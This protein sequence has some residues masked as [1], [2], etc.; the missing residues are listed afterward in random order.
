MTESH[1]DKVEI[2][3]VEDDE[4]HAELIMD[5]LKA[6]GAANPIRR[7]RDGQAVLDFLA[8]QRFAPGAKVPFL[9]ILDIRIPK[10]DGQEVLRRIKSTDGLRAMPVV[11]LTTTDDP[12]EIS[13]SYRLGCNAYITK[14]VDYADFIAVM[15]VL[16][17]FIR[18]LRI[19]GCESSA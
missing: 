19:S 4:G 12:R 5:G 17:R 18:I 6:A 11:M 15:N 16:G 3:L 7:F 13:T 8:G 14:P 1:S 9:V 2:L 10:V